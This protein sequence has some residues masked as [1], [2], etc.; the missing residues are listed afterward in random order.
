MKT[1][2]VQKVNKENVSLGQQSRPKEDHDKHPW[3]CLDI[4]SSKV[5]KV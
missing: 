4:N 1:G 5:V 2:S 3:I